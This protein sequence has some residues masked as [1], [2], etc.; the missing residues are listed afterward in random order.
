MTEVT[1]YS[2][3]LL[4]DQAASETFTELIDHLSGRFHGPRFDPHVTLLGW[5]T[6][7][8][9]EL[10]EATARLAQQLPASLRLRPQ[11]LGGDMY[12]FRCLYLKL[13]K[14]AE[15]ANAH[16]RASAAFKT[17]YAA[18]YMPHL[19]LLYGSLAASRRAAL[20]KRLSAQLP[21]AFSANRL[22][23]V[24]ITVAVADWRAVTTC[25]LAPG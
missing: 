12:Y 8:E 1:R 25:P 9:A 17:G 5:V 22:Q 19:S 21:G 14:T 6:G 11:G 13:E 2:L 24:H 7:A 10:A 20:I 4:P 15:L 3:W 18:D 23:L 16:E